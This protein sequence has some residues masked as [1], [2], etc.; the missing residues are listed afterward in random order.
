MTPAAPHHVE[1]EIALTHGKALIANAVVTVFI[2]LVI[3]GFW[4]VGTSGTITTVVTPSTPT[5]IAYVHAPPGVIVYAT[6]E[7]RP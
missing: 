5:C 4:A 6:C 2:S 3:Q 1:V 7:V